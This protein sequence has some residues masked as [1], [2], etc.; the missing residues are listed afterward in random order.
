MAIAAD[1]IF[2]K[3]RHVKQLTKCFKGKSVSKVKTLKPKTAEAKPNKNVTPKSSNVRTITPESIKFNTLEE[4]QAHFRSLGVDVDLSKATD[5]TH[6]EHVAKSLE[7]IKNMGINSQI[8]SITY[9]SF[10][11]RA[12]T[13][14]LRKRGLTRSA[15]PEGDI[16]WAYGASE[17]GH[18]FL[19]PKGAKYMS[20]GSNVAI[21]EV[22][23]YHTG[24]LQDNFVKHWN[25]VNPEI[26]LRP[27]DILAQVARKNNMTVDR[28][29][30]VMTSKLNSEVRAYSPEADENFSDMF[31]LMV[32]GKQSFSKGS[33]LFYDMAGGARMPNKV[34]NG[35][36]YDDYMT[37]LYLDAERILTNYIK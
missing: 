12:L 23:H 22:G 20:N 34:I 30:E 7:Q 36:K 13:E 33:M 4:A 6:V 11:E 32:E 2:A 3:G 17:K 26:P 24:V 31:S 1:C 28:L 19:N 15:L 35:L 9:T 21:H 14:A 25:S 8:K 16:S 5:L 10:E 37:D 18:I 29:K 27:N